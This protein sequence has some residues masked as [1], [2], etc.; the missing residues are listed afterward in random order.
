VVRAG[1]P[2][3][4]D[5]PGGIF[6]AE[7]T[8]GLTIQLRRDTGDDG[9]GAEMIFWF[10]LHRD[11]GIEAGA[12]FI[13]GAAM[14]RGGWVYVGERAGNKPSAGEK[15]VITA[16]CEK[17]IAEVLMPRFLPKIRPTQFNYPIAI[18]GKWHGNKY[19]FI[20]RYRSDDPRSYTPEF[21]AP[22]A[23]LGF[24][25]RDR[26]DLSYYRHTGEWFCI[27]EHVSLVEA[28]DLIASDSHFTP[29]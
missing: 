15:S 17:L 16:A 25:N 23:R 11:S 8:S 1:R 13:C 29:C 9:V 19:R 22:F 3:T 20:T 24:V 14:A 4:A 5:R 10:A 2:S 6:R 18:Y 21:E 12:A 27:F 28:L 7:Q 26:F